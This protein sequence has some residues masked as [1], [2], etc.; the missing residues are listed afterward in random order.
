MHLRG[1]IDDFLDVIFAEAS[2]TCIVELAN[3]RN[4]FGFGYRNDPDPVG[5]GASSLR[6]LLNSEYHRPQRRDGDA[7]R[8]HRRSHWLRIGGAF[9][10][11]GG[12][13]EDKYV[14]VVCLLRWFNN[15]HK[16]KTHEQKKR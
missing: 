8:H 16:K 5:F 1:F 3:H 14:S 15:K 11:I 7:L 6:R 2:V 9:W 10:I 12:R 13:L 4:G